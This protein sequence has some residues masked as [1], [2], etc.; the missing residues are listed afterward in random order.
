MLIN[1]YKFYI[2]IIFIY[3]NTFYYFAKYNAYFKIL[4]KYIHTYKALIFC[5]H[6]IFVSSFSFKNHVDSTLK[7]ND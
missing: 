6:L 4:I 3:I 1:Y 7:K 5:M 2:Y